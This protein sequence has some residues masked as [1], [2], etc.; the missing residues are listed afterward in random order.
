VRIGLHT[1]NI[2]KT[3]EDFLGMAV[4]VAA[5]ITG[6]ARGGEILVS[7]ACREYTERLGRWSFGHSADLSLKGI[8]KAQRVYTLDWVE[9]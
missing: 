3:E 7:S 2:F 5:R 8:A 9:D 4:V 6:Q 1:G